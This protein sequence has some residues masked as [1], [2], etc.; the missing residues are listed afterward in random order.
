MSQKT[1]KLVEHRHAT[2]NIKWKLVNNQW[3]NC[4]NKFGVQNKFGQCVPCRAL[5]D[6]FSQSYFITERYVQR[7]RLSRNPT[8]AQTQGISSD[9]TETYHR[10][11]IH[12]KHRHTGWHKTI[13]CAIVSHITGTTPSIK[14]NTS[15]WKFPKDIKLADEKFDQ[16]RGIDLVIGAD[17]FYEML[18][19]DRRTRSGNYPV[20]QETD[21][22]W[23]LS[24]RT[25]ATTTQQ[26]PQH[27]FLLREANSLEYNLNRFWEVEPVE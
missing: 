22:G 8:Q 14:L 27:T 5:L 12:L 2:S 25:P 7:L 20:L 9:N 21:L 11:S 4:H 17:L 6:N 18:R 24:G 1:L 26:D 16:T 15:T 3:S 13:N 19:S 23:T 10:V